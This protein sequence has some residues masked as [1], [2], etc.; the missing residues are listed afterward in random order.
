MLKTL[1]STTFT[2]SLEKIRVGVSVDSRK[3]YGDRVELDYKDN[4]GGGEVDSN[5][6]GDHEDIKEKTN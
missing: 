3:E 5:E 4:I 1:G 6:V 2:T